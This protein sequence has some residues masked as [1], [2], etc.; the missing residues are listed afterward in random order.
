MLCSSHHQK[1]RPDICNVCFVANK[2][3]RPDMAEQLRRNSK[4][5]D[6]ADIP[7]AAMRL[8][9]RRSD[10]VEPTL[11]LSDESMAIGLR[12]FT[13]G[14]FKKN[15]FDDLVKTWLFLPAGQNEQLHANIQTEDLFKPFE[16]DSRFSH[17]FAFRNTL[18]KLMRELRICQRPLI[19][20]VTTL[21]DF[22]VGLR[23]VAK[24]MGFTFPPAPVE[25]Q[26]F[27]NNKT[28]DYLTYLVPGPEDI[29]PLPTIMDPRDGAE[30]S[31]EASRV[32][33][34]NHEINIKLIK[35]YRDASVKNWEGVYEVART[36]VLKV[37]AELQFYMELYSHCDGAMRDLVKERLLTL[38]RPNL[39]GAVAGN[40]LPQD[41]RGGGWVRPAWG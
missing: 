7:G 30:L 1:L 32:V 15:H 29:M 22:S 31:E 34:A 27:G 12:L 11:I 4:A 24:D 10:E 2:I 17:V 21:T 33:H 28:E 20:A 41:K 37:E 13:M 16:H 40:N 3:I 9:G 36:N 23:R 8:L 5:M 14:S 35:E 6:L 25:R 39:R 38:F 18:V 26:V 19:L